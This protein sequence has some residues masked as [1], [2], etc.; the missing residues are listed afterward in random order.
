VNAIRV[1]KIRNKTIWIAAAV[2]AAVAV[3]AGAGIA[4]AAG[5][6]DTRLTDNELAR[7]GRAA[8]AQVGPGTVTDARHRT[9][10]GAP[11]EVETRLPNGVEVT[12]ELDAA[13]T[14]VWVSAPGWTGAAASGLAPRVL[15][16]VE[17]AGV[18]RTSAEQAAL[19][20]VGS[21]AVT[22]FRRSTALD[23]AFEVEVTLHGGTRKVVKLTERIEV[24]HSDGPA[25]AR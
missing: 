22:D 8:L 4:S 25:T 7:A 18:D 24:V 23:H 9:I 15:T 17:L 13:F 14:V 2:I 11:F 6:D 21:G 10:A 3:G 16:Q 12:V 5:S 20:E 19:A 1:P